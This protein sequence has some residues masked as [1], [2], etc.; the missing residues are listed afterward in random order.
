MTRSE[1]KKYNMIFREAAKISELL[2]GKNDK[3]EF[4][5]GEKK[6]SHLIK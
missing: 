3:Y 4:L 5:K 2:S 6:Y 1:I